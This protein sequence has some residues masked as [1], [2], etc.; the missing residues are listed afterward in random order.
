M[1]WKC[2]T[3][4]QTLELIIINT[5]PFSLQ[6]IELINYL[7]TAS[8]SIDA[9]NYWQQ[10]S[11]GS[12]VAHCRMYQS[13]RDTSAHRLHSPTN[14]WMQLS[15]CLLCMQS[16]LHVWSC[17]VHPGKWTVWGCTAAAD[18]VEGSCPQISSLPLDCQLHWSFREKNPTNFTW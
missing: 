13:D 14:C 8:P 10:K 5:Y 2:V 15:G 17:Q 6:A 18:A 4:K 3:N 9:S 7:L 16:C 11:S 12:L 1:N